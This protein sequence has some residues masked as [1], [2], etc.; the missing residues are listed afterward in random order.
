MVNITVNTR[1][2]E[3]KL[4]LLAKEA[5]VSPGQVIK[6][7][8]RLITQNI[9]QLTAPKSLAQGRKAVKN[10]ME[11]VVTILPHEGG[12]GDHWET[13][14]RIARAGNVP[15]LQKVLGGWKGSPEF[16]TSSAPIKPEHLRKRT[17]YGRVKSRA[18]LFAFARTVNGYLRTVQKNVGWAKGAWVSALIATGGRAPNWYGK[19]AAVAGDVSFSWGENPYIHARA[20]SIKIPNYQQ[21]TVDAAVRNR[22]RVTQTKINRLIAGKAT[23]LG[24]VTILGSK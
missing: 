3:N 8:A 16:T 6:E 22:E 21:R 2:L 24:F 23:N 4:Y 1:E 13:V 5:R 9:I 14:N 15:A 11:N 12:L 18:R 17:K 10:D 7:E 20:K 19:H